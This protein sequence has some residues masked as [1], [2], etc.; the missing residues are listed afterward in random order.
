MG[1]PF[2]AGLFGLGPWGIPPFFGSS[3]PAGP[4]INGAAGAVIECHAVA[5]STGGEVAIV[6]IPIDGSAGAVIQCHARALSAGAQIGP[7][8]KPGGSRSGTN[9][10]WWGPAGPV[11]TLHLLGLALDKTKK[12]SE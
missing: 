12:E 11:Q 8:P 2:T 5:L 7:K 10:W 4:T 3:A 1:A 9:F 6:A